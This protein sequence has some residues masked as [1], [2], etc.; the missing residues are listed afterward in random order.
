V[1]PAGLLPT[2]F[3]Y[4]GDGQETTTPTAEPTPTTNVT[5]EET[6]KDGSDRSA[7]ILPNLSSGERLGFFV[8]IGLTVLLVVAIMLTAMGRSHRLKLGDEHEAVAVNARSPIPFQ[9]TAG[10]FNSSA[11]YARPTSVGHLGIHPTLYAE[12]P[13]HS[14]MPNEGYVGV[15]AWAAELDGVRLPHG[16][17]DPNDFSDTGSYLD[18]AAKPYACV[19]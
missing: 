15:P 3:T 17:S 1:R 12:R 5:I 8:A 14:A 18:P 2:T 7:G 4:V 10:I 16:T 11:L 6:R 19:R 9:S 13:H